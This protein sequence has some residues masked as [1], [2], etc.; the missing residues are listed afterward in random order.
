LRDYWIDGYELI[1]P[2]KNTSI[3]NVFTAAFGGPIR[4]ERIYK[5]N[6]SGTYGTST[7]EWEP[8]VGDFYNPD[9]YLD[10][11]EPEE[12]NQVYQKH[13]IG[14][15]VHDVTDIPYCHL[16]KAEHLEHKIT[17]KGLAFVLKHGHDNIYI[18]NGYQVYGI[19]LFAAEPKKIRNC[20]GSFG[21][22][23]CALLTDCPKSIL[24]VA[25]DD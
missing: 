18:A 17:E 1:F 25:E 22:G 16:E 12:F 2:S 20:L 7:G 8:E 6:E 13:I 15:G 23:A 24:L 14:H 4:R 21:R 19:F 5:Y 9:S 3:E 11:G 10:D